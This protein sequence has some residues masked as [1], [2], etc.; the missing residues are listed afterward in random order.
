MNHYTILGYSEPIIAMIMETLYSLH[1]DYSVEIVQN[2]E[3]STIHPFSINTISYQIILEKDWIKKE[4]SNIILG[5]GTTQT[6]IKVFDFFKNNHQIFISDYINVFHHSAQIAPNVETGNGILIQPLSTIAPYACIGNFVTINRNSSIG[7][8]TQIDDFTTISP[9]VTI[10]GF[11]N[12]G[13]GVTI[14][15]GATIID[16][17]KIGKN[18]VVGAGAV[19]TKDI[20][21]NVIA[22]GNPAKVIRE[23]K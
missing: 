2:I 5:V 19:V 11:C 3:L 18:S 4:N 21:E 12:I 13:V 23:I 14:G 1:N 6:K 17:I 9:G 7:H 10:A 8:H 20:P 15:A 22:Y 16:N